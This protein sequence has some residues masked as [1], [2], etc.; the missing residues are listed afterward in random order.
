[1]P[2]FSYKGRSIRGALVQGELE[3]VS[4][5][6]VATQLFNTGITP[7]DINEKTTSTNNVES[8]LVR[9]QAKRPS[10][11]D[12]I[13]FTRQMYTMMKSGVPI[14]RAMNGIISSTR[15]VYLA[16]ALKESLSYLESGRDLAS[17]LGRHPEIFPTLFISMVR[18]GEETGRLDEAFMRITRYLELEKETRQRIKAAIRYPIF[19]IVAIAIAMVVIN[20]FVIPTFAALFAKAD[21]ALPWQTRLLMMTSDFFVA[22]WPVLLAGLIG[23]AIGFRSYIQT[24]KGRYWW[25]R[26]KLRIPIIG[27]IIHRATLGRFARAFSMALTS[28]VPLVQAMTV[29]A[30]SVDNEYVAEHILNMRNGIERGESL[31]R[32]ATITGQFT[33]LVL[34][35]LSVGE[36]TGEV[37][38]L[39]VEVADFY[40]REVDYDIKNLSSSIE[41][42]LI[43]AIGIMVLIL[44]LGV[45]LPMWDISQAV[46]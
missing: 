16:D 33:P 40:E 42:V 37:D 30:R 1:M 3:A 7:I 4:V 13:L 31:T 39:L 38:N 27:N 36:E 45:F 34:Q 29:V 46:G 10:L 20:I 17:S 23:A 22:W 26:N 6:A 12:I 5:D 9:L 21:V 14:V 19:V 18:V 32:T 41:P 24:E 44:A 35:M 2:N 28:G 43:I 8:L 25:D 11:D 15:N